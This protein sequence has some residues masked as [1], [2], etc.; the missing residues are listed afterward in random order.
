[1]GAVALI[2]VITSAKVASRRQQLLP[3]L[4][5]GDGRAERDLSGDGG[6]ACGLVRRRADVA[7]RFVVVAKTSR[8]HAG[9]TFWQVDF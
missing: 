1:V 8:P 6:R 5:R 4:D 3:P 2:T 9:F 7:V